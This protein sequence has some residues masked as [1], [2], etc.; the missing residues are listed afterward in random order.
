MTRQ[1]WFGEF[2]CTQVS[3]RTHTQHTKLDLQQP[4]IMVQFKQFSHIAFSSIKAQ[5]K[6]PILT[7]ALHKTFDPYN[8]HVQ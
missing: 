8:L 1:S 5:T 6:A 3:E 7:Y 2:V 4:S